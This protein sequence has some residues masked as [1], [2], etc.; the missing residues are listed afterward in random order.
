MGTKSGRQGL[1]EMTVIPVNILKGALECAS[2]A[3]TSAVPPPRYALHPVESGGKDLNKCQ[4][5]VRAPRM[6]SLFFP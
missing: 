3:T 2:V 6:V 5:R 1:S 4:G